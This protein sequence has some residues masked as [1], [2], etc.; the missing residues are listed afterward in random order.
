MTAVPETI[1]DRVR[2]LIL[3]MASGTD[4]EVVSARN[5]ITRTL[6]ANQIDWHDLAETLVAPVPATAAPP[7]PQTRFR[8]LPDGW[9]EIVSP[10]LI[11]IITTIES[12]VKLNA[13]SKDFL[14]GLRTKCLMYPTLRLSPK[15]YKWLDS[16]ML[17]IP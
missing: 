8:T 3:M 9:W 14:D 13:S 11:D 5:L 17:V 2:T 12:E 10:D 6:K 7:R 4:A 15:Q 16:L 1:R